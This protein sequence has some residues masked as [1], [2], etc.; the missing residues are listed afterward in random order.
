MIRFEAGLLFTALCH[1]LSFEH[2]IARFL[3]LFSHALLHRT[4]THTHT[5]FWDPPNDYFFTQ[6]RQPAHSWLLGCWGF[7]IDILFATFVSTTS[8]IT[9]SK[10]ETDQPIRQECL[11]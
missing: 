7:T 9:N 1:L 10:R 4:H 6:L 8:T 11:W 3:F 5:G 2:A